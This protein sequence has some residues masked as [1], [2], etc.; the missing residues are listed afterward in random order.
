MKFSVFFFFLTW[1]KKKL[2]DTHLNRLLKDTFFS[3]QIGFTFSVPV[4]KTAELSGSSSISEPITSSSS[5]K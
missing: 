4:A 2:F 5:G 1:N 3:L